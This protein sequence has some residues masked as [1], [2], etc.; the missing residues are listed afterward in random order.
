MSSPCNK[1]QSCHKVLKRMEPDGSESEMGQQRGSK[2]SKKSS[3]VG[4]KQGSKLG[5]LYDTCT[6]CGEKGGDLRPHPFLVP[7]VPIC[8]KDLTFYNS[9]GGVFEKGN[10]GKEKYCRW[11]GRHVFVR[12]VYMF[13]M[14]WPLLRFNVN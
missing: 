10:D 9:G 12:T 11:Y 6:A 5:S 13:D 8:Q 7:A 1:D 14:R 2:I 4:A 3:S